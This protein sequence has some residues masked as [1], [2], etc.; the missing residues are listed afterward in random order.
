MRA[1]LEEEIDLVEGQTVR[2]TEVIDK[3]WWRGEV[4]GRSG[5]FPSSFVRVVD[6][7]PGDT[8]PAT[9]DVSCYLKASLRS[10]D[11]YMNTANAF[12]GLDEN[13]KALSNN[14]SDTK[15]A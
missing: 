6:A 1:Q 3:D 10:H 11:D 13:L 2:I 9:A 4:D 14:F 5:I 8:P 12:R 15:P 7:F